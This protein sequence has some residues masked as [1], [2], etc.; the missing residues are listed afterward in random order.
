[1]ASRYRLSVEA[2]KDLAEIWEWIA[3]DSLELAGRIR[4]DFRELF[5]SLARLPHQGHVREDLTK[6]PVRFMRLHHFLVV[7][8]PSA[9]PLHILAVLRG[10]RN[11]KRILRQRQ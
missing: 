8:D 10:T 7:Y 1:M 3:Q 11:V 2:V 4:S 6:R 5:D 9:K